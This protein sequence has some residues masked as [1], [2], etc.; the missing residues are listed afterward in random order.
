MTTHKTKVLVPGRFVVPTK[1]DQ[2]LVNSLAKE[3][4]E[5]LLCAITLMDGSNYHNEVSMR[6]IEEVFRHLPNVHVV[7][8]HQYLESDADIAK[9]YNVDAVIYY[10][11]ND[12]GKLNETRVKLFNTNISVK[13]DERVPH[14]TP[15]LDIDESNPLC[16]SYWWCM[17]LQQEAVEK[18]TLQIL[19]MHCLQNNLIDAWRIESQTPGQIDPRRLAQ[20]IITDELMAT[21]GFWMQILAMHQHLLKMQFSLNGTLDYAEILLATCCMELQSD[22]LFCHYV[23]QA[24]LSRERVMAY[25]CF[26]KKAPWHTTNTSELTNAEKV[27]YDA[28][29]STL[30]LPNEHWHKYFAK[31]VQAYFVD[32][33]N[34]KQG[35]DAK[36]YCM[37][38]TAFLKTLDEKKRIFIMDKAHDSYE[39]N[40]RENIRWERAYLA[41]LSCGANKK[42]LEK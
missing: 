40:A 6:T 36:Q 14:G 39:K 38:R 3:Y 32:H 17:L 22:E 35:Y 9:A 27:L 25:R 24:R 12:I 15:G 23:A 41:S 42:L 10:L 8:R 34:Q 29:W 37:E 4:N 26:L 11:K 1:A 19:A 20:S 7:S 5:V 33:L 21:P 28:Y 31:Q 30:A 2:I 13:Y 18:S 16:Q